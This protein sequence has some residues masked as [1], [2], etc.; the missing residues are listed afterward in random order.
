MSRVRI[1]GIDPGSLSTGYGIIDVASGG[2]QH[3][4]NGCVRP[5]KDQP[6]SARLQVI[7]ESV[8]ELVDTY[9]PDQAA[10]EQAFMYR[11]AATALKLGQARGVAICAL[12][13][14]GLSVDE[15]APRQVKQAVVGRGGADKFQVQ[16]MVCAILGLREKPQEDAA[17]ALAVAICHGHFQASAQRI[18]LPAAYLGRRR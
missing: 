11:N 9:Q 12:G 2:S 10:V 15:Y 17:D 5:P 18:G 6:M 1:L 3:V 16:H 13:R 4:D 8:S 14:A 7:F